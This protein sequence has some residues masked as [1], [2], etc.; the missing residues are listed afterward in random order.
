MSFRR[1][2]AVAL[3]CA[4]PFSPAFAADEAAAPTVGWVM[5]WKSGT[6]L[7]YAAEDLTTNNLA[8]RERTR[9]TATATVR[10]TEASEQGFLQAWSWRD[11]RYVVEEGDKANEAAMREFA[12]A[13]GDVTLEVELD[14]DGNYARVRNLAQI[15]PRMRQ[16][17]RPLVLSGIDQSLAR[18]SDP[19]KRE[20]ARAPAMKHVEAFV[21]RML[22]PAMLET[23]LTRNIQWYNGF[24]GI[25]I[26][27]DQNYEAKLELP[28][29]MGGAPIPVTVTFSLSVAEDEPEDLFVVF[30]QKID[31]ENGG[32]AVTA[33]IEGLLGVTLPEEQKQ[34]GIS[35]V[36]E[37]L[38][39]VH[40][41]TGVVEMF[42]S[43]RTVQAGDQSKVERHRLR[44]ADNEHAHVW[45][46]E[47]VETAGAE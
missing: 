17:V 3:S 43:T 19:A 5:P 22:A 36:D 35:I 47:Q 40:R 29:P 44:L 34:Q 23:M 18:I 25:D 7:E 42:E 26:E 37:G 10:I 2:L 33:M 21:D 12:A 38:F 27:P 20:K 9:S 6:T 13:M 14:G 32:A 31:R 39:I 28:S 16:A 4:L 46:D 41:P 15:T 1:T 24:V 45:R 30:E 8:G 11:A